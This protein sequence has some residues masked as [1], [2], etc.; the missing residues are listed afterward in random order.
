[1]NTFR[2]TVLHWANER[3]DALIGAPPMWG[4]NEAVEMQVLLLME[5][6]ALALRPQE[7][8]A[9][10]E[11][12]FELYTTFL[13]QTFP[14]RGP[15]PLCELEGAP[16]QQTLRSFRQLL[17]ARII[18]EDP[19][20]HADLVIRLQYKLG[21]RPTAQSFT[22][23][24]DD[25]RRAARA[26]ARSADKRTG[27]VRKEVEA[28]T[29]FS[30]R[31]V[32]LSQPNGVAA[33]A[34]LLLDRGVSTQQHLFA[35]EEVRGALASLASTA[36]WLES[37]EN[38]AALPIDD[39]DA[40]VRAAVQT[41]R[42]LPRRDVDLVELGGGL[43]GSPKPFTLRAAHEVRCVSI[44][45]AQ[46]APRHFNEADEIR[47]IDLDRGTLI[48][49][50]G[51]RLTCYVPNLVLGTEIREVGIRARVHGQLYH[52]PLSP[53]FVIAESVEIEDS[54]PSQAS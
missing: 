7:S 3:L 4:S 6:R 44:L 13:R 18:K 37:G 35:L 28:V 43:T 2:E 54:E 38:V 31:D 9:S 24:C 49:G 47:G 25:V 45:A 23:Y 17:E 51:R 53:P 41:M 26:F 14:E 21:H 27:R 46:S 1:M 42:L 15:A 12:V 8:I 16:F 39:N 48:L 22:G 40:R 29:D 5:L 32:R 11:A 50:K 19:F 36:H 10:P 34:W 33:E 52:P 30:L 20:Q